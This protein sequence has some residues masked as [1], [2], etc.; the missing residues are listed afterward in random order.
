MNFNPEKKSFLKSA[1]NC[2]SAASINM[3]SH[4]YQSLSE[5]S[6][7][8]LCLYQDIAYISQVIKFFITKIPLSRRSILSLKFQCDFLDSKCSFPKSSFHA[9]GE[10][11]LRHW[12]CYA[13][14][15]IPKSYAIFWRNI[16]KLFLRMNS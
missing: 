16:S 8:L 4:Q 13:N 5:A 7:N 6:W 9:L 15:F 10:E 1:I 3:Y 14:F 11:R 2:Y 12:L